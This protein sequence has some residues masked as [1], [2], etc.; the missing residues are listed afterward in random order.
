M[1]H[2]TQK[3]ENFT[4]RNGLADRGAG[5]NLSY[6]SANI[7]NCNFIDNI[8]TGTGSHINTCGSNEIRNCFF[9]PEE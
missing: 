9:L 1:K 5:I 7:S 3:V 4:I 2:Q 6:A 8:V